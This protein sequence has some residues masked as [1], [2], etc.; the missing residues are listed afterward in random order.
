MSQPIKL[1][2]DETFDHAVL[3]SDKPVLVNFTATWAAP[4]RNL[5]PVLAAYAK[6]NDALSVAKIDVGGDA[7]GAEVENAE[8]FNRY[9][10]RVYPTLLLFR[11]GKVAG[12]AIGEMNADKLN[13]WTQDILNKPADNDI[14]P[15]DFRAYSAQFYQQLET[16]QKSHMVGLG[17][18]VAMGVSAIEL[19]GAAL[20]ATVGGPFGMAVAAPTALPCGA[21]GVKAAIDKDNMPQPVGNKALSL[22]FNLSASATGM[23]LVLA[24]AANMGVKA[25]CVVA[26]TYFLAVGGLRLFADVA[27]IFGGAPKRDNLGPKGPG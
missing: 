2:S 10:I 21:Q 13:A 7:P 14:T 16:A 15:E 26:A 5:A 1:L 23:G 24:P 22:I 17:R 8:S 4:C 27:S 11:D 3:K 20:F 19:A 12:M 25:A 18:R 9:D 6:E